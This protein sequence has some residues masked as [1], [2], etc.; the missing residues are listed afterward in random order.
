MRKYPFL[1]LALLAACTRFAVAEDIRPT[2]H[3][4]LNA[5]GAME[6]IRVTSPGHCK[7]VQAIVRG[8]DSHAD[9]EIPGWLRT[10]FNAKEVTYSRIL[11]TTLPP[12]RDLS[13]ILDDT[14]YRGR[15][16]L[17]RRGAQIFPIKS[18]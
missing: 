13:F 5:P 10:T 2:K 4:N 18:P 14:S 16:T 8:L 1:V 15:V 12:Q 6:E 17:D 11:L 9:G 7:K 3:V